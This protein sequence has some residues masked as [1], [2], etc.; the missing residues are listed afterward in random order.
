MARERVEK[1]FDELF[2]RVEDVA[3]KEKADSVRLMVKNLLDE[4]QHKVG[5][6]EYSY[7]GGQKDNV[8]YLPLLSEPGKK[9]EKFASVTSMRDVEPDVDLTLNKFVSDFP[10]QNVETEETQE[11]QEEAEDVL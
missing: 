8:K 9:R 7:V 4:W 6:E 5:R 3:G 2:R 1:E 10:Y 11:N